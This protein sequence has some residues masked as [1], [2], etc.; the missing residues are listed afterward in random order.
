[1]RRI[2]IALDSQQ[3]ARAL[4]GFLLQEFPHKAA[5]FK[6]CDS[7][8][9]ETK[10]GKAFVENINTN[11]AKEPLWCLSYT[12]TIYVGVS[13][14]VDAFDLVFGIFTGVLTP[15]EIRQALA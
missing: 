15:S 7:E 12:P 5:G 9:S 14:D 4:E 11:L 3:E 13:I 8:F 6:V 1:M 2:A 10:E